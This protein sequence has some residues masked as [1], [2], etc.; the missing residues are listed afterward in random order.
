MPQD[1]LYPLRRE[2]LLNE[3]RSRAVIAKGVLGDIL[4]DRLATEFAT[5][6]RASD[7]QKRYVQSYVKQFGGLLRCYPVKSI[8][9]VLPAI[10]LDQHN[11]EHDRADCLR[12]QGERDERG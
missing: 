2:P 6:L 1:R 4:D 12:C 8:A 10:D 5:S 3:Q 11:G 7:Y 9:R